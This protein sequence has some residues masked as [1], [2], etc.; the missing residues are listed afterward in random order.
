MRFKGLN[1]NEYVLVI[2][3]ETKEYDNGN[4]NTRLIGI[5]LVGRNRDKVDLLKN[6][7]NCYTL[8]FQ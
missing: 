3:K 1:S 8:D 5:K 2:D 7:S 6:W 4:S